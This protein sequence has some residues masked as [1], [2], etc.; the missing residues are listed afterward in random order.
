MAQ[1][2]MD[3]T[4]ATKIASGAQIAL[5]VA[6]LTGIAGATL[7]GT[8]EVKAPEGPLGLVDLP[9]L[10]QTGPT[11]APASSVDNAGIA[12]R[13]AV[14]GNAPQKPPPPDAPAPGPGDETPAPPPTPALALE[15]LGQVGLGNKKMALVRY[16]EAQ[17]ILSVDDIIGP[18]TIKEISHLTLVVDESGARTEIDLKPKSA[19]VVTRASTNPAGAMAGGNVANPAAAAAMRRAADAARMARMN[20]KANVPMVRA[21]SPQGFEARYNAVME[22]LKSSGQFQNEEDMQAAAKRLLEAEDGNK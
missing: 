5:G 6:L 10:G 14:I 8:R 12:E 7:V 3:R 11:V 22:R 19:D 4:K 2:T 18:Y 9:P 17:R 21:N 20:A 15:F 13:L 1:G 16:N